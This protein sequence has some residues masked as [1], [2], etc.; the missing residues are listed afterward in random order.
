M[1]GMNG[2]AVLLKPSDALATVTIHLLPGNNV[3]V[4]ADSLDLAGVNLVLDK[5]KAALVA[6]AQIGVMPK[7]PP[8]VA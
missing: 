6:Q 8:P 1:R 3:K 5:A 7:Q 4:E 2:A